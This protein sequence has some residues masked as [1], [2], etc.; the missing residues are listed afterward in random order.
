MSTVASPLHRLLVARGRGDAARFRRWYREVTVADTLAEG[1]A[2]R[3]LRT[4]LKAPLRAAREAR[5]GVDRYGHTGEEG[6]V[7]RA[8]QRARLW[9]LNLRHGIA[10][11]TFYRYRLYAPDRRAYADGVVQSWEAGCA[12][13]LLAADGYAAAAEML[14]DKRSF[15][16]WCAAHGIATIPLLRSF[17]DGRV[18]P[19]P[20]AAPLPHADLFSKTALGYGG[21]AAA[22]WRWSG[23]GR[24]ARDG[25]SHDEAGLLAELAVRS[26]D[27]PVVL[28][29]SV[30]NHH[31]I[32]G[33]GG[34]A[35]ATVRVMTTQR[36]G[37]AP[38]PLLAVMRMGAADAEMDNF[39]QGGM[40][41]AV[42]L[43][44]GRLGRAL[45]MDDDLRTHRFDV[46]PDTGAR[47]TG[48][49]LPHW[50]AALDLALR[51]HAALGEYPCVGWDVAILDDGPVLLEGNWNPGVRI[52]QLPLDAPLGDTEFVRCLDAH[53]GHRF[54]APDWGRLRRHAKWEPHRGDGA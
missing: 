41:C 37:A 50:A 12:Y 44:T 22:R 24:W 2:G 23:D 25:R 38:A 52:A 42:D 33:V 21:A 32:A 51:A 18:E 8:R 16:A 20:A 45:G 10:T 30:A 49:E 47:I 4:V 13:R 27:G 26:V 36:P 34:A 9:W 29:R 39:S 14:A 3:L 43:A 54:P 7:S 31:A 46:H 28:Q 1:G 53:L 48:I 15:A 6:G 40:V 19:V 35:L 11:D 17:A 5:R